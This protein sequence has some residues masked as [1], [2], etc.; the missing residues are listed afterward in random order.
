MKHNIL[1]CGCFDLLHIGHLNLLEGASRFGDVY[2][3][4][5]DDESISDKKGPHRPILP[6]KERLALVRAVRHV[7]DAKIFHFKTNKSEHYKELLK[8]S[9]ATIYA[10]GPDHAPE[11]LEDLLVA[12]K[13][14]VIFIPNKVQGT[15]NIEQKILSARF[16][17]QPVENSDNFYFPQGHVENAN[18]WGE[19]G[20][21]PD[22]NLNPDAP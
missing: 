22:E 2:V 19:L 20:E 13:I 3:G 5:G 7:T 1:I 15:T 14:P 8:W 21:T 16:R 4:V 6:E 10:Q 12:L 11:V 18:D 17:K 9:E